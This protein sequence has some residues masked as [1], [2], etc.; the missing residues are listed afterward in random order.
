MGPGH[1][2]PAL[3]GFREQVTALTLEGSPFGEVEDAI[4]AQPELTGDQKDALWL[5]AFSLRDRSEK[6]RQARALLAVAVEVT[7]AERDASRLREFR[8]GY[9][10]STERARPREFDAR[11]FPVP[12]PSPSFIERVA[13]LLIPD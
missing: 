7:A 5:F 10:R 11:G 6:R 4:D 3:G 8:G 2:R 9:P 12:Q 1:V 13:R